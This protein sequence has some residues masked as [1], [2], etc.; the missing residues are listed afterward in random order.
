RATIEADDTATLSAIG[1]TRPQLVAVG[2][3]TTLLIAAAG[4]TGGVLV[5][6]LLSPFTP[7]GEA[8]LADPFPGFAFDPYILLP[9]ALTA[10]IV[11]LAL[12]LRPVI[13]SARQAET[14]RVARPSRIV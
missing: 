13:R 2:M 7:L 3:A 4:V 11:V 10:I 14:A 8:R 1:A 6:F 12:G 9:G 5:A